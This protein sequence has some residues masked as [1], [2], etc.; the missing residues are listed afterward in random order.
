MGTLGDLLELLH[1]AHRRYRTARG[2]LRH[3]WS[4]S[5]SQKAREQWERQL[6]DAGHSHGTSYAMLVST[7]EGPPTEPP[8]RQEQVVRFWSEPPSRLRE[9]AETLAPERHVRVTVRDGDRW[10]TYSP[11]W[12]AMSNVGAGEEAER[13][14]VGG[15]EL[16]EALLDPAPWIPT[17]DF[18]PR[19]DTTLLGRR[20]IQV[21]ATGREPPAS[22]PLMFRGQ[23]AVGADE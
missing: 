14:S 13:M 7:G 12:G 18:E 15:G 3:W 4:M 23:L 16:M 11:E 21:R 10:W 2:V 22:D 17:L 9:E 20:A 1:G 6:R 8:D 19:D 5:L